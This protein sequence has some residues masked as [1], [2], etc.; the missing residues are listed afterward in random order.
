MAKTALKKEKWTLSFDPR[1]KRLL[2]KEARKKGIYPVSLLE[3]VVR[4]R[5]NPYGH[6]DVE[7]SVAYVQEIRKVSRDRS[8][9]AFLKEIREWQKSNS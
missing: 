8:D 6:S 5:F 1:L 7:D 3:D 2:I 4:D 9:E